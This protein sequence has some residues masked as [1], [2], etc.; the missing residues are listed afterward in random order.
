MM[1]GICSLGEQWEGDA[2]W[3]PCGFN[4]AWQS[5]SVGVRGGGKSTPTKQ[6]GP[7]LQLVWGGGRVGCGRW[8]VA[9][10]L[11][12]HL[13]G[14][15]S[16]CTGEDNCGC[17]ATTNTMGSEVVSSS[18]INVW[19]PDDASET[20]T[21]A[22]HVSLKS[23]GALPLPSIWKRWYSNTADLRTLQQ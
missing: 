9:K 19:P 4:R 14:K 15:D 12:H 21:D 23:M 17:A 22:I 2:C 5:A 16:A 20:Y 11:H 1:W 3:C 7:F 6:P 13:T 8:K 18:N 10:T